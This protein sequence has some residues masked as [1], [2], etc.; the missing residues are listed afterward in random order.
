[1][2][3]AVRRSVG[4]L[5]L[6]VL[7]GCTPSPDGADQELVECEPASSSGAKIEADRP[8]A[9]ADQAVR[10]QIS[11]LNPDESV[12][13]RARATDHRSGTWQAQ[14][15][16]VADTDGVVD[17]DRDAPESGT[18]QG[19]DGMGLFWSMDPPA[20]DPEQA[21]FLPIWPESARAFQVRLVVVC[22]DG[23][24]VARTALTREWMSEGVDHRS[25]GL[26][27]SGVVGDLYLPPA[28]V[29]PRTG[30]LLIGGSG[31][32][33]AHKY[34]AALLASHG[35]PAFALAYFG[36][37]GL[38][39]ELRDIP[40]EY[41]AD[42]AEL[43]AAESEVDSPVAVLGYSRGGEPALLMA[44]HFP[45]LVRGAVV[46]AGHYQVVGAFPSEGIAW[47]LDDEPLPPGQDIP[48][49]RLAGPVLA[50]A[51][52]DDASFWTSDAYA[53]QIVK[54]CESAQDTY[55]CEALVYPGAGHVV[56]TFPFQATGTTV[57]DH[58]TGEATDWGGTPEADEAARRD[59]WPRVLDF[60][61][62]LP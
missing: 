59:G 28:E 12:I 10:I 34:E 30:V 58:G 8:V 38:P 42:A 50:I 57:G 1:M 46:Y 25:V 62:T 32:G 56:G 47:T 13:V 44:Q 54:E 48:L 31:G 24:E 20:A 3:W 18:Y 60:L 16:F 49:D 36:E 39:D 26:E 51:G 23:T 53:E 29:E 33:V 61:A 41:F 6:G 27:E 19:V 17:L 15:T 7:A 35:H 43:L 2:R 45:E 37:P 14:A 4:V 55:S 22:A 5:L 21:R 52:D 9:L 11:G 40:L